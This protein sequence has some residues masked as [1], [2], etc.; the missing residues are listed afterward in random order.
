M[1]A[2]EITNPYPLFTEL[3]GD[4][5]CN[6]F[7]YIGTANLDPVTNPISVYWDVNS[8]VEADQPIR[9]INGY[10]SRSGTPSTIYTNSDYSITVK[11]KN[12][13]FICT[14]SSATNPSDTITSNLA[15]TANV[16]LGDYL[17]GQHR[18]L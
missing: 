3:N 1:A 15:N 6:G 9:T 16:S 18:T 8:Q 5:L 14:S 17:V 7:I 10:A 13:L 11:D 4:P 12:G 2:I